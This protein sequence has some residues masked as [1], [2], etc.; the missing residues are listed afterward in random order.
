MI[1]AS[2]KATTVTRDHNAMTVQLR[3][4]FQWERKRGLRYVDAKFHEAFLH[5]WRPRVFRPLKRIEDQWRP[6]GSAGSYGRLTT[7]FHSPKTIT[8]VLFHSN[9]KPFWN[10]THV[11][12][13]IHKTSYPKNLLIPT[14]NASHDDHLGSQHVRTNYRSCYGTRRLRYVL[15]SIVQKAK[16]LRKPFSQFWIFVKPLV[17]FFHL[18]TP[19]TTVEFQNFPK[20]ILKAFSHL[21]S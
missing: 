13:H 7:T 5:Y 14:E 8:T 15:N 17:R 3:V 16:P 20:S 18:N 10:H 21:Y 9:P 12:H 19:N 4:Y 1:T 2:W 6:I 11:D